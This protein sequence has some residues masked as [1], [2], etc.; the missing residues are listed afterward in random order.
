M[1]KHE[2][3]EKTMKFQWENCITLFD[4]FC[5]LALIAQKDALDAFIFCY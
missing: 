2:K 4:F 3:T 1:K 5:F